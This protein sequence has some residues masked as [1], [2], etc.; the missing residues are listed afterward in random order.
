[1]SAVAETITLEE[2][3][4]VA[5]GA[6]LGFTIHRGFMDGTFDRDTGCIFVAQRA[7]RGNVDEEEVEYRLRLWGN[8][9]RGTTGRSANAPLDNDFL[10]EWVE[11]VYRVLESILPA[12]P[13]ALWFGRPTGVV[14][15]HPS[16]GV[17]VTIV[18]VGPNHYRM[19]V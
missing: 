3:I 12:T 14:F 8:S 17:E 18:A 5:V 7:E 1:M 19:N 13:G 6:E 2:A 11:R 4:R 9:K 16:R 10:E 15:D